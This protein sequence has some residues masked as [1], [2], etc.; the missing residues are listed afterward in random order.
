MDSDERDIFN[1]LK[2]WGKEFIGVKEICRRAGSK[3]RFHEDPDW[4][5]P[6]LIN[7]VDHGILERDGAGKYRIKPKSKKDKN[8]RWVSPQIAGLLKEKGIK[9]EGQE[10]SAEPNIEDF[11]QP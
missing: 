9:V 11:E 6:V 5:K 3:Q 4:A 10:D 7:M 1:Y 8:S 2:S